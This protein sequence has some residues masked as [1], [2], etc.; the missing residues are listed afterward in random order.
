M[1]ETL[2]GIRIDIEAQCTDRIFVP[3]V[4]RTRNITQRSGNSSARCRIRSTASGARSYI[5]R[6]CSV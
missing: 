3:F 4:R 2:L 5:A 1:A 6:L